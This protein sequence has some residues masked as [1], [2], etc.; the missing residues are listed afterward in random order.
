M[1]EHKKEDFIDFVRPIP[2]PRVIRTNAEPKPVQFDLSR[3]ALIVVDMQNDFL[4]P[5][6]WFP[7]RGSSA[8]P[9][10]HCI[11]VVEKLT[12]LCRSNDVKVIWVNWGVRDDVANLPH[13]VVQRGTAYDTKFPGYAEPSTTGK[14][15]I[16]VKGDFGSKTIEQLTV[17]PEDLT[18][19]KHRLSGFWDNELDAVLRKLGV[20]TLLLAGVNTDRCVFSTLQDASFIGYD[21]IMVDDA[22]GTPSP[23][24]VIK[25]IKYLTN[26]L[27]GACTTYD[28]LETAMKK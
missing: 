18:I 26:M 6:G 3:T 7:A 4:H 10:L 17:A 13:G 20:T 27:Y 11:P 28:D 9:I 24:Y 23:E 16:L 8:D 12:K 19:H 15:K 22:C 14:G 1:S 25:A 5:E 2:V 21:C